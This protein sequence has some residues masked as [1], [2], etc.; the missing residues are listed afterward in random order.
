MHNHP[1]G[2]DNY[3]VNVKTIRKIAQI[4][5]TFSK[6]AGLYV[7][8]ALSTTTITRINRSSLSS[9]NGG[10]L[11]VDLLLDLLHCIKVALDGRIIC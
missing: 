9:R 4:F 2:F 3:L 1:Y 7:R 10:R 11:L 6:K 8:G 5:V